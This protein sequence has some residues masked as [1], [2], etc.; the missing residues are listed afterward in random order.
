[1]LCGD[2]SWLTPESLLSGPD[3]RFRLFVSV[4]AV[5]GVCCTSVVASDR[6][7]KLCVRVVVF[8]GS[9]VAFGKLWVLLVAFGELW[10]LLVGAGEGG[11]SSASMVV[12][13]S[14]LPCDS[15]DSLVSLRELSSVS[16]CV[17]SSLPEEPLDSVVECL[18]R[19]LKV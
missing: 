10:V 9:V 8:G 13:D 5:F 11:G 16:C 15:E 14:I 12:L 6:F 1:M 2:D 19:K 3:D 18:P 4:S 17:V 7:G